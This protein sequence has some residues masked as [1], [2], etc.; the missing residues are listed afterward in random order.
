M[1]R[2]VGETTVDK[3][4]GDVIGMIGEGRNW[5]TVWAAKDTGLVSLDS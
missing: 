1:R 4:G 3:S 5:I 2:E